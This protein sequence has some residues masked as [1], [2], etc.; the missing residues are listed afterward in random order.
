MIPNASTGLVGLW[1]FNEA[2]GQT[3]T[4][5]SVT[6]NHGVLGTNNTVETTDPTRNALCD[7]GIVL[8]IFSPVE[9]LWL[10]S[11]A[12]GYILNYVHSFS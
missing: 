7:N 10:L 12:A 9:K 2:S 3:V 11:H 4:D 1:R 8:N 5:E 6:A